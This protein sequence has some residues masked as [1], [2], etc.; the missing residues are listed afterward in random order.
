M[1]EWPPHLIPVAVCGC[2]CT[3]GSPIYNHL[4]D[5]L[6]RLSSMADLPPASLETILRFLLD[7]IDKV[8]QSEGLIDKLCLR[9]K[10]TAEVRQ[11]RV[12]AFCLA[13]LSFSDRGLQKLADHFTHYKG[14]LGDEQVLNHLTAVTARVRGGEGRLGWSRF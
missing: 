12:L 7:F 13:H 2:V 11:W 4:P 14:A 1:C 5:M 3:G 6:S 10:G 8:K 9:F